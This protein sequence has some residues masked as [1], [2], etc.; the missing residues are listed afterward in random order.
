[1]KSKFFLAAFA[2]FM[3]FANFANAQGRGHHNRG[4]GGYGNNPNNNGQYNN[5][6][7]NNGN[8]NNNNTYYNN[9]NCGNNGGGYGNGYGRG[10]RVYRRPANFCQPAPVVVYTQPPVYV[11]RPRIYGRPR[12]NINIGF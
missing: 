4:N 7:Y 6:R 12:V 3:V 11:P 1:M 9:S 2:L 10:R 8:C 5:G